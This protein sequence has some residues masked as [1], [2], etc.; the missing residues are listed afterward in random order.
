MKL[1]RGSVITRNIPVG[2][3]RWLAS[4]KALVQNAGIGHADECDAGRATRR[5]GILRGDLRHTAA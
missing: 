2:L 4:V 1:Q 3:K 5:V